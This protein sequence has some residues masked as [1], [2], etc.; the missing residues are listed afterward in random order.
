MTPGHHTLVRN[1]S[2]SVT[3]EEVK[4]KSHVQTCEP[5]ECHTVTITALNAEGRLIFVN[6]A[7]CDWGGWVFKIKSGTLNDLSLSCDHDGCA[8]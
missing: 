4:Y 2:D 5:H 6:V 8:V 1:V 7:A 3:F